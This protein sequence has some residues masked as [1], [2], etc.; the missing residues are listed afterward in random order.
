MTDDSR[1]TTPIQTPRNSPR[2]T[3]SSDVGFRMIV[4]GAVLL[5]VSTVS[6]LAVKFSYMSCVP[7]FRGAEET[8]TC[9]SIQAGNTTMAARFKKEGCSIVPG[10]TAWEHPILQIA[11]I[12][13]SLMLCLPG[14]FLWKALKKKIALYTELEDDDSYVERKAGLLPATS[15]L[16]QAALIGILICAGDC[17]WYWGLEMMYA[18]TFNILR[19]TSSI[20]FVAALNRTHLAR[21]L[22]SNQA[23]GLLLVLG[24]CSELSVSEQLAHVSN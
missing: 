5:A 11:V 9:R 13:A 18:S 1:W 6:V 15:E 4:V 16:S 21:R 3:A 19:L 24:Q 20:I 23:Y 8:A 10:C 14:F 7:D 17:F 2:L 12:N 22:R